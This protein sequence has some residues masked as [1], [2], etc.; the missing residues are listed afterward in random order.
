MR[1]S[2]SLSLVAAAF[3]ACTCEG[4][5]PPPPDENVGRITAVAVEGGFELR[6]S[7][8]E[9]PVRSL[10][11][12]VTLEGAR[13]TAAETVGG[14][15]VLEAGLDAPKDDFTVVVGD[16]RRLNLP[17]SAVARV[18]TDA[19]PSAITLSRALAVDDAGARRT[20]TVVVP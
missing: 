2:L 11:V 3:A 4:P 9:R 19:A 20:V 13:A 8:L 12:D 15:D 16:T 17:A 18:T 1:I 10:Q 6:L 7:D 5:P 14:S